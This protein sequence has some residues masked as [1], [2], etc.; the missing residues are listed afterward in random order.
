MTIQICFYKRY[1]FTAITALTFS[2][3]MFIPTVFSAET[4]RISVDSNGVEG[5]GTSGAP[6]LS[7]D[8][9]Y[10]AFASF[11]SNLV[12]GD[13]NN[14]AD[15]FVHDHLTG[16]TTRVSMNSAGLQATQNFLPDQFARNGS[17]NPTISADGRYIAFNSYADNLVSNDTND[18]TDVFVHDRLTRK[19]TRVSVDSFGKESIDLIFSGGDW[20]TAPPSI[21]ADG[22]YVG[23]VYRAKL[24]K[25][26]D[27]SAAD[28]YFHDRQTGETRLVSV[29]SIGIAGNNDSDFPVL[30][31]D[32]RYIAFQS[33]ASNLV[34]GDTNSKDDI[35]I[36]DRQTRMT[37]R[38]SLNSSGI[39]GNGH[40]RHPTISTDGRYV[41]FESE[42]NNLVT[43]DTDNQGDVFVHDR[44]TGNTVLVS[45]SS[46]GWHGVRST[47]YGAMFPSICADGRYVAFSSTTPFT[48][49]TNGGEDVFVHDLVSGTTY[50]ASVDSAGNPSNKY[51]STSSAELE[52]KLQDVWYRKTSISADCNHVGFALRASDL[53]P[54]DTNSRVDAFVNSKDNTQPPSDCLFSWAEGNYPALFA[55]SGALTTIWSIYTYRYYSVTNAY[56]GL[57]STDNDVYYMGADGILQDEGPLSYWLPKSGC[58]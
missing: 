2:C 48:Y 49:D 43:N 50:I 27:T 33:S 56:L 58:Q 11:A 19:T 22:R 55:P 47:E 54:N 53:V 41:A 36:Y 17:A 8:G 31:A 37:T 39:Q 40:S 9:R 44:Q 42:A 10:V 12:S 4:V 26:D 6:S 51:P 13:T 18:S 5:D 20:Q 45:V 29:N 24:V 3:F 14:L 35:F 46:S 25:E 23:F 32:G 21:S 1:L 38:A 16:E 57:S 52:Y 30:S 34:S 15:I 28:I 7:S